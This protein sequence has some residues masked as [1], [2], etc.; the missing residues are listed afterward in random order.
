[1]INSSKCKNKMPEQAPEIRRTNF[2]ESATGFTESMAIREAMRC[3]NCRTRPC[4]K[5]GCPVHNHIPEFI[6]QVSMG[7]FEAAYQILCETTSLPAVCGRVCPQYEQCEGYCVRGLKGDPVSIGALERFVADWHRNHSKEDKAE[8]PA[9]NGK[10]VAVIGSGPAG[11]ACAGDLADKGFSVTIFEKNEKAGGVLTYGIP[12]FRLPKD[13]VQ[14]EIDGLLAKGVEIKTGTEVGKDI[15]TDD[16][17]TKEGFAAVFFG[18][19]AGI[20]STMDIP[21]EDQD[22]VMVASDYLVKINIDKDRSTKAKKIAIVGGGNVAMDAC[23]SAIRTGADKVYVVY[24]RSRAEMPADPSEVKE[25]EEEGIEFLFLTN[26]VEVKGQNGKITGLEC[27]RMELGEPDA[28]GRRRPVPV[29]G[30]NFVLDVDLCI[31]AIG[32]HFDEALNS[33]IKEVTVSKKGG[34]EA[35][36]ETQATSRK[37]VYAGGDTVTGPKTVIAAMGAGKRAA[38]AIAEY[39]S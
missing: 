28:S 35:D 30:S 33:G 17:L 21:G 32:T 24:R 39:L 6:Q 13:I 5:H 37:G 18:N 16:I 14:N 29:E 3:L 22:G 26:P 4:M 8:K 19:G 10:K 36:K 27:M 34:I 20:P 1:M 2:E 38:V 15:I 7:E 11:I 31:M 12:E 9:G 23:R 25:A